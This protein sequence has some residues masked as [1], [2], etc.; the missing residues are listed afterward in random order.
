MGSCKMKFSV[1]NELS[2]TVANVRLQLDSV[3]IFI[4]TNRKC[5]MGT[6]IKIL[7]R[8]F[9]TWSIFVRNRYE[10]RF[11]CE[12]SK[13]LNLLLYHFDHSEIKSSRWNI[14]PRSRR[15]VWENTLVKCPL[16]VVATNGGVAKSNLVYETN[17]FSSCEC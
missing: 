13:N 9:M 4:W 10:F 7:C 3:A 16:L 2:S 5:I 1:R 12:I 17:F 11:R 6:W 8:N 14:K 15:P